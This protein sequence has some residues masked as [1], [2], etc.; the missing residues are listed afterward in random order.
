MTNPTEAQQRLYDALRK[1][2]VPEPIARIKAER[3]SWSPYQTNALELDARR[4][5]R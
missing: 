4:D 1:Q 2:G 5:A 3:G